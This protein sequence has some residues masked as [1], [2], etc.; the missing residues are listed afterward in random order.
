MDEP[1]QEV[2]AAHAHGATEA[3]APDAG[4]RE[5]ARI[6]RS[7]G[8]MRELPAERGVTWMRISDAVA[9]GSGKIAGRGLN[10]EVDLARRIHRQPAVTRHAIRKRTHLLPPLSEFGGGDRLVRSVVRNALNRS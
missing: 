2:P 10:L 8:I 6:V 4:A 9:S 3:V 1:T 7:T 5:R